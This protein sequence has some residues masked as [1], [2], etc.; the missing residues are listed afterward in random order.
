[1]SCSFSCKCGERKKPL[2]RRNWVIHQ[3][4]CNH[5]AF[6]GYHWT[7]SDYSTVICRNPDCYG[8]GRTKAGYVDELY[9]LQGRKEAIGQ[10]G[11]VPR[12][13]TEPEW[14]LK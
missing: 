12:D 3:Y 1:M 13:K 8:G 6:N 2:N 11:I 5:S 9:I 10:A 7:S 4:R 14:W